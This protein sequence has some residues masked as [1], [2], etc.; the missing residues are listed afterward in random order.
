MFTCV[1]DETRTMTG[2]NKKCLS[3]LLNKVGKTKESM[4]EVE[5]LV[6]MTK[7]KK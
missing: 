3:F 1:Q 5:N 7:T 4:T 2:A 6:E